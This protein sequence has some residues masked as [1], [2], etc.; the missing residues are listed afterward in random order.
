MF[1]VLS[2]KVVSSVSDG[3]GLWSVGKI[4]NQ[5]THKTMFVELRI[6]RTFLGQD[7]NLPIPLPLKE[8]M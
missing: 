7:L 2:I 5:D 3:M 4:G 8:S 1:V 6:P